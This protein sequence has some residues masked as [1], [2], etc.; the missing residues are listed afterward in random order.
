MKKIFLLALLA[1]V[2]C[3]SGSHIVTGK[4][5]PAISVEAVKIYIEPPTNNFE[6]IGVVTATTGGVNQMAMDR[7]LNEIKSQAGQIG[8]NGI[9]LTPPNNQQTTTMIYTGYGFVPV[10]GDQTVLSGTAI[11]IAP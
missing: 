2:G 7:A 3:V 11:F 10:Q 9:F 8:A 6:K 4:I 1:M 5:H